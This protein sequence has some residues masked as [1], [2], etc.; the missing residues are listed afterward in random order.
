MTVNRLCSPLAAERWA[1]SCAGRPTAASGCPFG[2]AARVSCN[3][4]LGGRRRIEAPH[5]ERQPLSNSERAR[6][7]SAA[8][9]RAAPWLQRSEPPLI[10]FA[11]GLAVEI[12]SAAGSVDFV[13]IRLISSCRLT[14]FI[15]TNGSADPAGLR[16]E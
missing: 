10:R 9:A 12:N 13:P 16:R 2:P 3:A 11:G 8:P 1:F 6:S 4:E 5:R 14:T 7:A 15:E